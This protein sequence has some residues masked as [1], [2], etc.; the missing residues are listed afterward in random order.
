MISNRYN[1]PTLWVQDSKWKEG[2]TKSN[3][4]TINTLQA[5]SQKD[6]HYNTHDNGIKHKI[7][8]LFQDES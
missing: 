6:T 4:T 3:V 7:S 1:Y 2:R 5:E 8:K